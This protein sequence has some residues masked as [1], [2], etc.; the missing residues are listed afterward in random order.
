MRKPKAHRR[1]R[2]DMCTFFALAPWH[3]C[4]GMPGQGLQAAWKLVG[5]NNNH[6]T[7]MI[8]HQ[9]RKARRHSTRPTNKS[10]RT[11]PQPHLH[12]RGGGAG[13]KRQAGHAMTVIMP[14]AKCDCGV[15]VRTAPPGTASQG[16]TGQGRTDWTPL[17]HHAMHL[18]G[19]G[20]SGGRRRRRY[21]ASIGAAHTRNSQSHRTRTHTT[22]VW[23]AEGHAANDHRHRHGA[24]GRRQ[25]RTLT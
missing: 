4:H 2:E 6:K 10:R 21:G 12:S 9:Q 8:T 24:P 25:L 18:R 15:Q 23:H 22:F 11:T 7:N 17:T 19:R 14:N 20:K 3:T 16:P 5:A 13:H 1:A